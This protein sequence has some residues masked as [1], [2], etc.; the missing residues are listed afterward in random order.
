MV[1]V[2]QLCLASYNIHSCVGRDGRTDPARIARI[3]GELDPDIIALQEV[4]SRFGEVADTHQLNYLAGATGLQGIA[5]TTIF[6]PDSHYGNALLI[7]HRV[8]AVRRLDLSVA[9]A[10]EPRGALDVDLEVNGRVIRVIATH[11]GLDASERREQVKRLLAVLN[12]K[13]RDPVVFLAD[14]N[15]WFPL[16]RPLRWFKAHFGRFSAPRTFPALFPLLALD[17]IWISPQA[18]LVKMEV[19]AYKTPLARIASDHLPV[20]ARIAM[21]INHA[22]L[23]YKNHQDD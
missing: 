10:R 4:R 2:V 8:L 6:R 18:V 14:I 15:E 23:S 1:S 19:N 17:R 13:N 12:A 7:R 22:L 5:G 21:D 16:S 3:I 11:L 20:R 9:G